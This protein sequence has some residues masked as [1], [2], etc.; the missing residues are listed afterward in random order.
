MSKL[1]RIGQYLA[2]DT[3][4]ATHIYR[5]EKGTICVSYDGRAED[6]SADDVVGIISTQYG[7]TLEGFIAALRAACEDPRDRVI[8]AARAAVESFDPETDEWSTDLVETLKASIEA[9]DEA[10]ESDDE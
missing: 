10:E 7:E 2:N 3:T 9:L 5:S 1:T 4:L 6:S 8:R